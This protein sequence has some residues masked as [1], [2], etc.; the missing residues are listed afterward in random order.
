LTA[1]GCQCG[2]VR[3]TLRGGPYPLYACHCRDCQK[4]A[5]SAFGL[6]MPVPL[7]ALSLAGT[8]GEWERSAAGGRT[9]RCHFCPVCGTRLY[10]RSS[11]SR[12]FVTLKAGTLDDTSDLRVQA[13][14]WTCR[15]QP[16]V[17]LDPSLPAFDT[18]PDDLRGWRKQMMEEAGAW[19]R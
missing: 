7:D 6:S 11:A 2:A 9:T 3:Y 4:Q 1:G 13:H 17:T 15:K 12:S 16:W 8:L 10:H 19:Q 14:L 5:A 18:Q